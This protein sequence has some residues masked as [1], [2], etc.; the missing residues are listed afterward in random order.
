MCEAVMKRQEKRC[1]VDMREVDMRE[2]PYLF[3][4]V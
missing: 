2:V 3:G 4:G 1:E